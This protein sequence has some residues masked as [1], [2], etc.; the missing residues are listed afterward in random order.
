MAV[1]FF[2]ASFF[3]ENLT[4][5]EAGRSLARLFALALGIAGTFVFLLGF[6][7][8]G[9]D[10]S[11]S[12]HYGTPILIGVI[13][14]GIESIAFLIPEERLFIPPFFLLF[15]ALRPVRRGISK[16]FRGGR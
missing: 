11:R 5:G 6:A 15:L 8:L 13:A 9:E 4:A 16:L 2:A 7:L 10:Q 1:V 3:G 12:D 14:G